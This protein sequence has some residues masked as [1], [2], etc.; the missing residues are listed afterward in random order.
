V[1]DGRYKDIVKEV[2]SKSSKADDRTSS[3]FAHFKHPPQISLENGEINSCDLKESPATKEAKCGFGPKR[4]IKN[5]KSIHS[6][7]IVTVAVIF[8]LAFLA[9]SYLR[10]HGNVSAKMMPEK[11]SVSG[12]EIVSPLETQP[13]LDVRPESVSVESTSTKIIQNSTPL[14]GQHVIDWGLLLDQIS[15]KIPKT[16]QLSVL[17]SGDGSQMFLEGRALSADALHDFVDALSTVSQIKSAELT[18]TRIGKWNSQELLKFSISCGLA[19]GTKTPGSVDG[20]Y[21][22]SGFDRGK[23]FTP[24]EAE[25]FFADTQPICEQAGC[26]ARSLLPSP[27]DEVFEDKEPNGRITKKHAVLTILGGYQNILKA[28]EKLQ[29]RPQ[30][31]WFDSISIQENPGIGALECSMGISVYIADDPSRKN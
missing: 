19:S 16:V 31:V 15:A 12:S 5:K 14:D 21:K 8:V 20:D 22:N 11:K 29:N 10:R 4:I 28:V 23:L 3:L 18:Q 13:L 9:G 27:K 2:F 17:E 30:R 1:T 24:A 7:R 6:V 26:K 25:K